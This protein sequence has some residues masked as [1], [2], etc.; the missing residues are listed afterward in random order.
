MQITPI[1]ISHADELAALSKSIYR[2]YYL[3]LWYPGG[4]EWYMN[5]QA[6]HPDTL[7]SELADRNNLHFIVYEN[8]QPMGYL[9]IKIN[10]TL[11]E[12]EPWNSLE[13]ERIYLHKKIAGKGIGKQLMLLS[14]DIAKQHNKNM[15]FLKAMDSSTEAIGFYQKMGYTVCGTLTLPF[16]LLKESFRGMVILQKNISSRPGIARPE[17]KQPES[18]NPP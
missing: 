13:I 6:Y 18:Q 11:K 12:S 10:A 5:E 1:D 2:E 4:A 15:I 14:E 17:A 16:P 9:K 7:K 3:H 8:K